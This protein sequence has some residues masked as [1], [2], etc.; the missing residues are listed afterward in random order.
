M[1]LSGKIEIKCTDASA[2]VKVNLN[3]V[4]GSVKIVQAANKGSVITSSWTML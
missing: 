3:E 1:P 2:A 4:L